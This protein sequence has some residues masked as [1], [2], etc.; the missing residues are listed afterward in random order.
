MARNWEEA[1][2]KSIRETAYAT[3]RIEHEGKVINVD[4]IMPLHG[5]P[6]VY[7]HN[8]A[9]D[10]PRAKIGAREVDDPSLVWKPY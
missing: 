6:R 7:Y 2:R 1:A 8:V 9:L 10:V 4:Y 5:T 3:K